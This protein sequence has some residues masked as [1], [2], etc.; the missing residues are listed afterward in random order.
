MPARNIFGWQKPCYLLGEG[1]TK[2]FKELMD[3]TDWETYGTGKYEKCADCMAHCGY[4][5][6]AANAALTNPLKAMWVALRGVRTSGPMAPEINLDHQR[7]AQYIFSSEVQKRLSEIRRDEAL[8]AEQKTSTAAQGTQ[9]AVEIDSGRDQ[10]AQCRR[11]PRQATQHLA[12]VDLAV[13]LD[14]GSRQRRQ[15]ARRRIADD[16]QRRE[17]KA[18]LGG[19]GGGDMALHI[20]GRR[21][22]LGT[23]RGFSRLGDD[24]LLDARKAAPDDPSASHG[25]TGNQFFIERQT[26]Q[27]AGIAGQHFGRHHDVAGSQRGIQSAGDAEADDASDGRWVK[28][29]QQGSQLLRIATAADDRHTGP[30]RYA[31]LMHHT[32]HDKYRPRVDSIAHEQVVPR[33]QIHIPT[34]T[35]LLLVLFKFRY[36][37]SAQS[38][39]NF[40]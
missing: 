4:E 40:E 34:P 18:R 8:T 21:P 10:R 19:V 31:G 3:T 35:T 16:A 33:P 13:R 2:T 12:Q 22:C 37:A 26:G 6:T 23:Q 39:K 29:R 14:R 27:P 36:R 1:Y 9:R 25:D 11:V 15:R 20:D 7:P 24:Y 17:W 32:S 5:P 28:H 30:S 38:G